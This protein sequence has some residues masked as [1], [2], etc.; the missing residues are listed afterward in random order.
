MIAI[1]VISKVQSNV[2]PYVVTL[3]VDTDHKNH[4]TFFVGNT[5]TIP[6]YQRHSMDLGMPTAG[7]FTFDPND[8]FATFI[9]DEK[10]KV[11]K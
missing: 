10:I 2:S 8:Q 9:P 7:L 6:Y 1:G 5:M 11:R 3:P 4:M